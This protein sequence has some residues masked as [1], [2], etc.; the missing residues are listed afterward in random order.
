VKSGRMPRLGSSTCLVVSGACR[1]L[2]APLV[3]SVAFSTN[4]LLRRG[5]IR[6][7]TEIASEKAAAAVADRPGSD[8]I[9]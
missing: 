1:F 6:R 3:V 5:D 2:D 9:W 8:F 4:H 7:R